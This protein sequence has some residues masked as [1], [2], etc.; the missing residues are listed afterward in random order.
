MIHTVGPV[1]HGGDA[2]EDELLALCYR[3]S[4]RLAEENN[5]RSLAFPA[6]STGAFGF[7]LDRA[8]RIAVQETVSYLKDSGKIDLVEFVCFDPGSFSVYEAVLAESY[9]RG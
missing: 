2:E 1:W 8:T 6:I 4:L 5:I 7:P 3:N 9:L